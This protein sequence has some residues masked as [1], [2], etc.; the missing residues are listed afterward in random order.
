MFLFSP[1]H[2]L[3]AFFFQSDCSGCQSPSC[4]GFCVGTLP[5][6]NRAG[7]PVWHA[8]LLLVLGFLVLVLV[9]FRLF[10]SLAFL[11]LSFYPLW[12]RRR[13]LHVPDSLCPWRWGA[14]SC[15][16]P[17]AL[18]F[19]VLALLPPCCVAAG[20]SFSRHLWLALAG[21]LLSGFF[22]HFLQCFLVCEEGGFVPH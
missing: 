1:L 16:W 15:C 9:H 10:L 3:Y 19:C 14:C 7:T 22:S 18:A 20:P 12:A 5:V 21:F 8:S 11:S 4:R 13:R 17:A 6:R 2:P